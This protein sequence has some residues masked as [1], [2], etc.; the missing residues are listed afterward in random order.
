MEAARWVSGKREEE[1]HNLRIQYI[2]PRNHISRPLHR[3]DFPVPLPN[4]ILLTVED[5]RTRPVVSHV[6]DLADARS[7][8]SAKDILSIR[9]L[10]LSFRINGG[11]RPQTMK[12]GG[13]ARPSATATATPPTSLRPHC[14]D[15]TIANVREW[16]RTL[17]I[18]HIPNSFRFLHS[19][20]RRIQMRARYSTVIMASNNSH[21]AIA[22]IHFMVVAIVDASRLEASMVGSIEIYKI[23]ITNLFFLNQKSLRLVARQHIVLYSPPVTRF[24]P[25]LSGAVIREQPL[26]LQSQLVQFFSYNPCPPRHRSP[27]D[28]QLIHC[29]IGQ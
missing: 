9:S 22:H 27:A 13:A 10:F 11:D 3:P 14:T 25:A 17:R 4:K 8:G 15:T 19:L 2:Q 28:R 21:E 23:R 12:S 6:N 16:R 29:H 18:F 20:S 1:I 5:T 24:L 7:Y 26:N